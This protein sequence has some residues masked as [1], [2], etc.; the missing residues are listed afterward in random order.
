MKVWK[1]NVPSN[2]VT[3]A[4]KFKRQRKADLPFELR[5]VI[6]LCLIFLAP[7]DGLFTVENNMNNKFLHLWLKH[8]GKCIKKT[9]VKAVTNQ[10]AQLTEI[11]IEVNKK[12]CSCPAANGIEHIASFF[13]DTNRILTEAFMRAIEELQTKLAANQKLINIQQSDSHQEPYHLSPGVSL[14]PHCEKFEDQRC[15]HAQNKKVWPAFGEQ[16]RR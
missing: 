16:W 1:F 9:V 4:V 14:E 15:H 5:I 6:I 3:E 10:K 8:K 12:N 7:R 2:F 11:V 13:D